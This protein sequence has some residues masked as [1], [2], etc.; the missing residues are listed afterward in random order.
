M[1]LEYKRS[2]S[3]HPPVVEIV[4]V[5]P[6]FGSLPCTMSHTQGIF[7]RKPGDLAHLLSEVRNIVRMV[8]C[9]ERL[10]VLRA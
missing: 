1:S 4:L 8:A 7:L 6:F 5:E 10:E 2:P 9:I 3:R